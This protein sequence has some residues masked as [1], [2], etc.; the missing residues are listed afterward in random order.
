MNQTNPPDLDSTPSH[1]PV[2]RPAAWQST[3]THWTNTCTPHDPPSRPTSRPTSRKQSSLEHVTLF[4]PAR[5]TRKSPDPDAST[6]ASFRVDHCLGLRSRNRSR[7]SSRPR[8]VCIGSRRP[9][10]LTWA[11][12]SGSRSALSRAGGRRVSGRD[13]RVPHGKFGASEIIL[14]PRRMWTTWEKD[15]EI[16]F[17]KTP[18]KWMEFYKKL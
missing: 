6:D 1:L 11:A 13:N 3:G 17:W 16:S 18:Q 5:T 12:R 9:R 8:P 2:V 15:Y 10:R 14:S 7:W 4:V